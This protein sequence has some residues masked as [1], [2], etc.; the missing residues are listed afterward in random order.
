MES[1][2]VAQRTARNVIAKVTSHGLALEAAETDLVMLFTHA[3]SNLRGYVETNAVNIMFPSAAENGVPAGVV[4]LCLVLSKDVTSREEASTQPVTFAALR[5]I[6][7]GTVMR[8]S[9][10]RSATYAVEGALVHVLVDLVTRDDVLPAPAQSDSFAAR[11]KRTLAEE[12]GADW[13]L[14]LRGTAA[15]D[16]D[17]DIISRAVAY[18]LSLTEQKCRV[19]V[20]LSNGKYTVTLFG[21]MA[22]EAR[23]VEVLCQEMSIRLVNAW[24]CAER[25]FGAGPARVPT[26]ALASV[27]ELRSDVSASSDSRRPGS[28]KGGRYTPYSKEGGVLHRLLSWRRT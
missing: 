6:S 2:N 17:H 19:Q 11:V 14:D 12:D 22:L 24:V 26:I 20:V 4:R 5:Q 18:L 13:M 7:D 23:D 27:V 10:V 16:S 25:R 8:A 1:G 9:M 3:T 28:R 15:S 21:A